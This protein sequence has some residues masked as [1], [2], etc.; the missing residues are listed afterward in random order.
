MGTVTVTIDP[1]GFS[2]IDGSNAGMM[3]RA[4]ITMST[5]YATG[6]DTIS[7]ASF[8]LGSITKLDIQGGGVSG[9]T[10][11]ILFEGTPVPGPVTKVQAFWSGAQTARFQ[12]VTS[13]TDLSASVVSCIA[14]GT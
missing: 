9:G 1:D 2:P 3:V 12:E 6:G 4:V 14:F 13:G 8:G 7:A 5:T 10:L 11:A